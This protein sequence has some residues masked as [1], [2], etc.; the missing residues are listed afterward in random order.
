MFI[1]FSFKLPVAN[2]E[3]TTL[4]KL[5]RK[6]GFRPSNS[7]NEKVDGNPLLEKLLQE[8]LAFKGIK[9]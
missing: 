3:T 5:V 2:L 1:I 9:Q 8:I 4:G 7:Q 6:K